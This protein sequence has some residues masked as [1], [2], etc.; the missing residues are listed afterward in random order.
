MIGVGVED[1]LD[2][3]V[4]RVPCPKGD[5][6][7]PLQ[8]LI[9]DSVFNSFRGIIAY[10]KVLNG[11]IHQGDKVM[12]IKNNYNIQWIKQNS[13]GKDEK[14][15]GIFN[16]DTGTLISIDRRAGTMV[17]DF[18][19]RL[20]NYP[21]DNVKE[22]EHAFAMTV[23]KSQGSEFEAVIM[24]VI[25]VPP[26]LCYRNLF[27]TAVTRAKSKMITIGSRDTILRMVEN[28]RK[29]KRYSALKDLLKVE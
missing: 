6:N 17:I 8:A 25:D 23:H 4:D 10:F 3:I 22:L 19:G 28:D 14:G 16:G 13:R 24:P 26:N 7:A 20:A 12:Q 27:Y 21:L 1:V 5:K 11:S 29:I 18:D 2:A 15:E 9:F